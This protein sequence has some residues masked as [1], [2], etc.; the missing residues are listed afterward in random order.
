ML[1]NMPSATIACMY[2]VVVVIVL[3]ITQQY[4]FIDSAGFSTRTEEAFALPRDT[5]T[6]IR[7]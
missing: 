2:N 5:K 1:I 6:L 4:I 3:L 7:Q